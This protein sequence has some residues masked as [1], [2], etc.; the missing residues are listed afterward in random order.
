MCEV[1]GNWGEE[2][3]T[4]LGYDLI[5]ESADPACSFHVKREE[6]RMIYLFI[7]CLFVCVFMA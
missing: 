3:K 4:D 2:N 5:A 7:Y 1:G 6:S